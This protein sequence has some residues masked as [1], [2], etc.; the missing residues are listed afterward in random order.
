MPTTSQANATLSPIPEPGID[1]VAAPPWWLTRPDEIRRFLESLPGVAVEEIGRTA[2]GRPIL[3]AGIGPREMLPGRTSAS[4]SGAQASGN[5]S[6]FYGT[7]QRTCPVLMFL[8]AAHGTEFEG[9]V[10]AL[11]YLNIIATGKDL[12]GRDQPEMAARGRR[13]RFVVIPILNVDGRERAA[14]VRHWININPAYFEMITQ[15]LD[16]DG[17]I[18]T[19]GDNKAFFPQPLD[20]RK[21]LGTYF[22]DAGV[23]LVYDF[24]LGP[25]MQPE[26]AALIRFVRREMPDCVILSHSN[27]GS[28]VGG[29]SGLMPESFRVRVLQMGAAV[30]LRC[31]RQGMARDRIPTGGDGTAFY[32]TD[33]IYHAC[34]ALPVLVEFPEGWQNMP[35]NHQDIL[36]IGLTVIDE[37][38]NFGLEYGFRPAGRAR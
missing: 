19:W 18:T 17:R 34:G 26:N 36:D 9:T 12:A 22:N 16:T 23:N 15:G 3:A 25:D 31:K 1:L 10:A 28:L 30:G 8:G 24:Q 20:K 5:V 33:A 6:A 7:G 21:I 29:P 37:I 35:D 11:N 14:H 32:Q 4:L 2:G 38:A 27:A 13:L